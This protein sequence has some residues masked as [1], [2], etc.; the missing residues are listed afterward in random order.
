VVDVFQRVNRLPRGPVLRAGVWLLVA[1][2]VLVAAGCQQATSSGFSGL[3]ADWQPVFPDEPRFF[4]FGEVVYPGDYPYPPPDDVIA[5]LWAA[6]PTGSADVSQVQVLRPGR[7]GD[8][9]AVMTFDLALL[10]GSA[11]DPLAPVIRDG[12][13]V[14]VPTVDRGRS[15]TVR[16]SAARR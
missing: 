1:A 5:M 3:P 2:A 6:Q 9:H 12:D 4:I 16:L 8:M 13:V 14:F 7:N 15:V 11:G 10:N